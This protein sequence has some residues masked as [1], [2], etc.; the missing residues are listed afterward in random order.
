[1]E[2]NKI[3]AYYK[4]KELDEVQEALRKRDEEEDR[5]NMNFLKDFVQGGSEDVID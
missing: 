3:N 2:G 4:N 1:M 5:E